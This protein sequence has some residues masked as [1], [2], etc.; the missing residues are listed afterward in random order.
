MVQPHLRSSFSSFSPPSV[1]GREGGIS[2]L[3]QGHGLVQGLGQ[4]PGQGQEQGVDMRRMFVGVIASMRSTID[5]LEG[6]VAAQAKT[7]K[8]QEELIKALSC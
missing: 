2:G 8:G 7:I 1:L 4:G 5:A 6:Q 3:V